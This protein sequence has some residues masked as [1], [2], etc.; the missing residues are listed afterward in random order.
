MWAKDSTIVAGAQAVSIN[1]RYK[2]H[3]GLRITY[4]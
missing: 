4:V 3:T 2:A 1:R